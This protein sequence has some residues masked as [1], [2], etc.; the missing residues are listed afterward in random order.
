MVQKSCMQLGDQRL[1][2]CMCVMGNGITWA[3]ASWNG[4]NVSKCSILLN[5]VKKT[6]KIAADGAKT[7]RVNK[8]E[9]ED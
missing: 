6:N 3:L 9:V 7:R 1:E 5:F 4:C 8:L 2:T